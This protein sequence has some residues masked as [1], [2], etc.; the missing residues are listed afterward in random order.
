MPPTALLLLAADADSRQI[1]ART[2]LDAAGHAFKP[3]AFQSPGLLEA[4]DVSLCIVDSA[5]A[6]EAAAAFCHRWRSGPGEAAPILWL[7]DTGD[8]RLAGWRAGADAVLARPFLAGEL[9]AQVEALLRQREER[10][11]LA[12][13]AAEAQ[14][15]N[16]SAVSLYQQHDADFRLARRIQRAC[17]PLHLPAVETPLFAVSHRERA[18]SGGDFYNVARVDEDHVAVFLGDVM[19]SSLT[20]SLLATFIHQNVVP[21]QIHGRSYRLVPP[22]E[23]LAGLNR[24]LAGLSLPEPPLV[25][26]TYCLL[27]AKTGLLTYACAG[28][29]PPLYLPP[30]GPAA[31]WPAFG[32]MLGQAEANHPLQSATLKAGDRLLLF[33]DGLHGTDPATRPALLAAADKHWALPL[34][35]LVEL[36]T[37]DLLSQT[38]DPDDFTMLGL[39]LA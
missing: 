28:H 26:M 20:A 3:W 6:V 37:Q 12:A 24:G 18:G 22:D 1:D 39:E 34:P 16:Q 19:G 32:T 14:Q 4:S 29:T 35:S 17:R 30:A 31:F 8:T 10:Q 9:T 21:K 15:V 7:A 13:A 27:N 33:T 11:R 38:P 36:L 5:G 25:R 23:V 2:A